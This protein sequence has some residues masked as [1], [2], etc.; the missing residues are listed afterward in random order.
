MGISPTKPSL[1]LQDVIRR[2]PFHMS[3][4]ITKDFTKIEKDNVITRYILG[5]GYDSTTV[6]AF[7]EKGREFKTSYPNRPV[8]RAM[9]DEQGK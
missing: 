1:N 9:L 2:V 4:Q 6:S 5:G 7:D 3:A 8:N